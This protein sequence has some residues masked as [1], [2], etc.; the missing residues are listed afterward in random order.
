MNILLT[1]IPVEEKDTYSAY[2]FAAPRMPPLGL[3]YVAGVLE[4]DGHKVKILDCV[5][6]KITT[7]N[8]IAI[9]NEFKPEIVGLSSS[10]ITYNKAKATIKAIKSAFPNIRTVFGGPHISMFKDKVLADVPELDIG[11]YG[12]GERTFQ[13]LANGKAPPLVLGA[14]YR[15]SAG[16]IVVNPPQPQIKN[17]DEL[18]LPARHLL[19]DIKRYS[20]TPLRSMKGIMVSMVTSRGCPLGC[21]YCD[22]A[23]FSGFRGHSPDYIFKEI[24]SIGEDIAF[25]SFEDDNFG[26]DKVRLKDF[27][28]EKINRG[29][30]FKWGCSMRLEWIDN[31]TAALMKKSGCATLY[32]GIESGNQDMIYYVN[33]RMTLSL[34]REKLQIVKKHRIQAYGSFIIGLPKDTRETMEQTVKFAMSLPLDGASFNIYTPY[35]NTTLREEAKKYGSVS[36]NWDDYSDH[37]PHTP[38]LLNGITE[39]ELLD[40]QK[41]AYR[42][43]YMRPKYIL[44][45]IDKVLNADF[46]KKSLAAM[47]VFIAKPGPA[48]A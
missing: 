21:K 27:C 25:I 38:F 7:D 9:I 11:V 3:A 46:V 45:H 28:A 5:M 6:D 19:P 48:A 24:D 42:R 33:R 35:P 43:F 2:A 37:A 39:N 34:I 12:E 18:P 41:N 13:E 44:M 20:H 8:V 26:F 15:D 1:T 29:Y 47:K 17:L 31:E 30:K 40:I 16:K 23:T 22:Q 14:I 10:I 36:D 4:K 32:F